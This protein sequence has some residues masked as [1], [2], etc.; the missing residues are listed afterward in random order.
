MAIQ[1]KHIRAVLGIALMIASVVSV[2]LH[3]HN[4][5]VS[6]AWELAHAWLFPVLLFVGGYN[7]YSKAAL[8]DL[9]SEGRRLVRRR[10]EDR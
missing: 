1:G 7:L 9:F 6:N 2:F 8:R 3:P 10:R 4:E 5:P